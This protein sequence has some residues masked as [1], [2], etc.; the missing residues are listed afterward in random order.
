VTFSKPTIAAIT[1]LVIEQSSK[2]TVCCQEGLVKM[3][4][5]PLTTSNI[6]ILAEDVQAFAKHAKRT[7]I[8]AEDVRLAARRR[9]A[10]VRRY[11]EVRHMLS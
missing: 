9:P 5:W 2:P 6:G 8:Q 3:V 10:L 11:L 7:T 1:K 4:D